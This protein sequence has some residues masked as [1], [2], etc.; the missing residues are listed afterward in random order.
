MGR[1]IKK[2]IFFVLML[3]LIFSVVACGGGEKVAEEP[4][5]PFVVAS[6]E[7]NGDFYAGWTNSSYDNGIRQMVW[8]FGL[9]QPTVSGEVVDSPLITGKTVSSDLKTWT[10]TLVKGAKFHNGEDLT[11]SDV[12]FTYEFYMDKEALGAT[13]GSSNLHEYIDTIEVDEAANTVTFH[14]KKVSY[15]VD[16]DVFM[17]FLFPDETITKGANEEGITVQQYVKAHISNPIGYGPY[18]MVEYK[19]AEYVKFEVFDGYLDKK[20][21]I[22]EVIVKVVPS[23]TELDQLLQGEVDILTSQVESEKID[24]AKADPKFTYNDYFRHGGGT[25]V[26]H[27]DY[28]PTQL[29]EVRQAFAYVFNRPKVIELFLGQYGIASQGPY[30][31]NMW[32]MYDDDEMDLVGTAAE[33]RFEKSLINYDILDADGKFDEAANIAKAHELLDAAAA[34][35]DGAYAK[36][37]GNGKDGYLWEGEPLNIK[38]TY[39]SFWSDTY[40]L[41]WNEDY[42]SKLGFNVSLTGLDWPVMY[43]HWTGNIEEER[44][45]NA[46]VGGIGYVIKE[47]PKNDFATEKI[48]PWGGASTNGPRFSGG[49]SYTSAEWDALLDS[50]EA[51]NPV[52]GRDEYRANWREYV[53]AF[54]KEIPIIPVY[55]N[56]YHDL[57]TVDLENFKTNALW[58]WPYALPLANWKKK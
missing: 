17:T 43:G 45:Y 46:F 36:L 2:G 54:N 35:T 53:K 33:S 27:C 38:I 14:L 6:A 13:G 37:T 15:T 57:Y 40:N 16:A 4:Q 23:E 5:R 39:T 31:K 18:K 41:V 42:V 24:A 3:A 51:A 9:M 8:R 25:V 55:S 20:P 56:N 22:K 32:M 10:F 48:L 28:G 58:E 19:E 26:L 21:A 52:T 12:K 7:F 34:K 30:S 47:N 50:I 1:F 11:A 44:Q 29:T 49:S